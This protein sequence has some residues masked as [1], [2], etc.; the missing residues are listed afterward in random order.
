M[1]PNLKLMGFYKP[2]QYKNR[3]TQVKI[4]PIISR[5]KKKIKGKRNI[6]ITPLIFVLDTGSLPYHQRIALF[7]AFP[8][9]LN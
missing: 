3:E 1:F 5:G 8:C 7:Y 2:E 4:G 6:K 9:Y